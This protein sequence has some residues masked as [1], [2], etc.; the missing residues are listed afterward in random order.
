MRNV[1]SPLTTE[2]TVRAGECDSPVVS[3][4]SRNLPSGDQSNEG[5]GCSEET[6]LPKLTSLRSELGFRRSASLC[7]SLG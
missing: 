6:N 4:P 7:C 5:S 1:F 3:A 2:M